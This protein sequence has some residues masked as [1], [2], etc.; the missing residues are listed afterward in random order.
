MNNL[1]FPN[2]ALG[3]HFFR[4]GRERHAPG[5]INKPIIPLL[6][7]FFLK[8]FPINSKWAREKQQAHPFW[9]LL[10]LKYF[11]PEIP[12]TILIH[13]TILWFELYSGLSPSDVFE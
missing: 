6:D 5:C 1:E 12:M 13:Q 4:F 10:S 9:G 3:L 2:S 7:K 8:K 11:L